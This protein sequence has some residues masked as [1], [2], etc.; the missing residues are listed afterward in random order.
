MLPSVGFER[1]IVGTFLVDVT[2]GVEDEETVGAFGF[3]S[4]IPGIGDGAGVGGAPEPI[5][6]SRAPPPELGVGSDGLVG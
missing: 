2:I 3:A 5:L 6:L 1:P 4:P